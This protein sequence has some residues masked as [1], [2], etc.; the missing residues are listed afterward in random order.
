M[1]LLRTCSGFDSLLHRQSGFLC[2]KFLLLIVILLSAACSAN[3]TPA[4]AKP[5]YIEEAN[6]RSAY[7]YSAASL[8]F[9]QGDFETADTLYRLALSFDPQSPQIRKSLLDTNIQRFLGAAISA[10]VVEALVDSLV[11]EN[12]LDEAML[13]SA[14]WVYLQTNNSPQL[15]LITNQLYTRFPSARNYLV[16][17]FFE[18]RYW[19][20]KKPELL[21][22]ALRL[23]GSDVQSLNVLAQLFTEIN[24]AKAVIALEMIRKVTPSL[25]A[26]ETLLKLLFGI[27]DLKKARR[28]YLSYRY[29]ED[30]QYIE[31]YLDLAFINSHYEEIFVH[32]EQILQSQDR[33]LTQRL[34]ATAF[35][36]KNT[37]VL[38]EV[39]KHI[40]LWK[41]EVKE[42][43]EIYA[44]LLAGQL[45]NIIPVGSQDYAGRIY[46]IRDA[47]SIISLSLLRYTEQMSDPKT[48][49]TAEFIEDFSTRINTINAPLLQDYLPVLLRFSKDGGDE[50]E[51]VHSRYQFVNS[52]MD[53]GYGNKEDYDFMM[54]YYHR[55]KMDEARYDLLREAIDRFP[56]EAVYLNDLGYSYLLQDIKLDEAYDLISRALLLDP[57]NPHYLDSMAWFHYQRGEYQLALDFMSIPLKMQD[58]PSE[59]AYHIGMIHLKLGDRDSALKYFLQTSLMDDDYARKAKAELDILLPQK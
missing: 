46:S 12:N 20:K 51:F 52:I 43:S 22:E 11:T 6:L 56:E 27:K 53:K 30:K 25:V 31:Q 38:A 14:Y 16:R 40:N 1:K 8:H 44:V 24:P 35:F 48:E 34:A 19:E 28:I 13:N 50:N 45:Y 23:A 37:K 55:M 18:F 2:I 32:K 47:E 17:F 7:F 41:P 5:A 33:K 4:V 26:D 49:I 59:I 3:K 54:Q 29:P 42:D 58:M 9:F 57:Q 21:D 39:E 10:S 15:D 36:A